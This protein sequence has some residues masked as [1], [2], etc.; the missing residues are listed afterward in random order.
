MLPQ[1]SAHWRYVV[2]ARIE[3]H[4]QGK[5]NSKQRVGEDGQGEGQ[6]SECLGSISKARKISGALMIGDKYTL[7]ACIL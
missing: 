1:V 6:C 3:T 2:L 5:P 7:N 4:G